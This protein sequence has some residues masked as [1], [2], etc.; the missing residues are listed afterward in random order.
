LRSE[1]RNSEA[2]QY[3]KTVERLLQTTAN[4]YLYSQTK[5]ENSNEDELPIS[6][7]H[8]TKSFLVSGK[9]EE[10]DFTT[11]INEVLSPR[12]EP[13]FLAGFTEII[14]R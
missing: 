13:T 4:F 1:E 12:I 6:N 9:A 2:V 8:L 7:T 11:R 10:V 3:L 5:S 14:K